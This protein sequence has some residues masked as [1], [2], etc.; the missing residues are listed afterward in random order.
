MS[1]TQT[2]MRQMEVGLFDPFGEL[3]QSEVFDLNVPHGGSHADETDDYAGGQKV[4]EFVGRFVAAQAG[5]GLAFT[6]E[7][8]FVDDGFEPGLEHP[9]LYE[10]IRTE[11][12]HPD[13]KITYLKS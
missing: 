1:E 12:Q 8:R 5:G 9:A 7:S 2:K 3:I 4:A 6:V 10:G 13:D 11:R